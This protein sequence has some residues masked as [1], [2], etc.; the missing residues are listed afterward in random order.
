MTEYQEREAFEQYARPKWRDPVDWEPAI[1]APANYNNYELN[2]AWKSWQARATITNPESPRQAE[3][4][5]LRIAAFEAAENA[6]DNLR[7]DPNPKNR[8][9]AN[10]C[11]VAIRELIKKEV[12]AGA[13][14]VQL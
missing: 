7:M 9:G 2:A 8:P 4:Y 6:C 14:A 13:Q 5:N 10:A 1:G 3:P 11:I 12:A